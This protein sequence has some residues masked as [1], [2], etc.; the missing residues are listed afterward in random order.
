MAVTKKAAQAAL[1]SLDLTKPKSDEGGKLGVEGLE[2]V[3]SEY[4]DAQAEIELLLEAQ[5][6]RRI[7][8]L[9][10]CGKK[11]RAEELDGHFYKTCA[12]ATDTDDVLTVSWGDRYRVLDV[13]HE[14]TLRRAFGKHFDDLFTRVVSVKLDKAAS[15][16]KIEEIVGPSRLDALTKQIRFGESLKLTAGFME[17]RAD[18]RPAFDEKTN[19]SIDTVV[20]QVQSDPS[21]KVVAAKDEG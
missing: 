15:L 18:L 9:E 21:L 8:I 5:K 1:K 14:P 7:K 20:A 16:G 2:Q 19:E 17:Q 11:R 10:A 3:A 12:V 13:S 6:G 4:R